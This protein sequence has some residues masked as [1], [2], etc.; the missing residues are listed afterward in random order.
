MPTYLH[1]LVH[2]AMLEREFEIEAPSWHQLFDAT[3][4]GEM[5]EYGDS[6]AVPARRTHID[7]A[8]TD[9]TARTKA[10]CSGDHG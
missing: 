4:S 9:I 5:G 7:P 8:V 1:R 10:S 3:C 2:S 6:I